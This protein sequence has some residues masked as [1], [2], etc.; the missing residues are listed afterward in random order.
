MSILK[1]R[2]VPTIL[3][4]MLVNNEEFQY[5]N[6]VRFERPD[7]TYTYI[8]DASTDIWWD[9][10]KYLANKLLS[11]GVINESSKASP[12][13]TSVV[14]DGNAI[15][16]VITDIANVIEVTTNTFNIEYSIE[17]NF[18]ELNFRE[19]DKLTII[20]QGNSH[21]AIVIGFP[22][23]NIISVSSSSLYSLSDVV[24]ISLSSEEIV[25]IL[26]D[27]SGPN[28]SSFIN[29]QIDIYRAYFQDGTIIG[30][31]IYMFKGI[32]NGVSFE[33][34]DS[35]IKVTWAITSQWGYFSEVKGRVTSD[36]FH[37]ALDSSGIPQPGSTI[38][39]EYAYDKGFE[40]AETSVNMIAKYVVQTPQVRTKT[41]KFL[42]IVT[43][44]EVETY[45]VPEDR[46]TDLSVNLQAKNI[47]V[48]YGVRTTTGIPVFADTLVGDSSSVY[49]AYVIS[50]GEIGGIY[51]I[52]IENQSL[53][54]TDQADFDARDEA[55]ALA[56]GDTSVSIYCR[57]RADRGDVLTGS[58]A[59]SASLVDNTIVLPD[60]SLVRFSSNYM[61]PIASTPVYSSDSGGLGYDEVLTISSPQEISVLFYTG[62]PDQTVC[63]LLKSLSD[64]QQFKI[65]NSYTT[66]PDDYWGTDHKLLDT[67]YAVAAIKIAEGETTIPDIEYIVRG[68]FI[69]CYNYDYSYE[70]ISGD[71]SK[72]EIGDIVSFSTGTSATIIDKFKFKNI[73]GDN[74]WRFRWDTPPNVLA[75]STFSMTNGSDTWVMGGYLVAPD[76]RV[77]I[78]PAMQLLD[79]MTSTRYGRGIDVNTGIDLVG[80][81]EAARKCDATSDVTIQLSST[82]SIGDTYRYSDP[83][84]GRLIFQGTVSKVKSGNY[85]TFTNVLGKLTNRWNS[86]KS[87]RVGDIL[88]DID[89]TLLYR[90][91][92][93]GTKSAIT[94]N[95]TSITR[96]ELTKVNGT[97]T[98]VYTVESSGNPVRDL[99]DSVIISGYS[100]YDCDSINYWRLCGWDEH[101]Q[102]YVTKYQTNLVIDTSTSI[103]DNIN[104]FLSHFNGILR[105]TEGKYSLDIEGVEPVVE[106]G[107]I[108]NI[109]SDD[110]IGKIQLSDQGTK[111]SFNSLAV[112]FADPAIKFEARNIGFFNSNYLAA[113]GNVPKKG[114]LSVP[115]V[116]NYYNTRLLAEYYLNKSRYGLTINATIRPSGVLFLPGTIIEV[117]YPRYNWDNK[118]FRIISINHQPSTLVDI[119]AE[120]YD[121]SFYLENRISRA[122]GSLSAPITR[123]VSI[124]TPSNLI[125]TSAETYDDLLDGV[126]LNWTNHPRATVGTV[127]TEIYASRSP[128]LYLSI[129]KV[130]EGSILEC[131]ETNHG[132]VVGMPVYP[133]TTY[134]NELFSGGRVYYVK[135]I[136]SNNQFTLTENKQVGDIVPLTTD[137]GVNFR[138]RTGSLLYSVPVPG[139]TYFDNVPATGTQAVEKYYWIRHKVIES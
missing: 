98:S 130:N 23:T 136:I 50:E 2:P 49:V 40:H 85:T 118:P 51:D 78:N 125:V 1:E 79:Y 54:C 14:L 73:D 4:D 41:K 119:V 68:K 70:G 84:T 132:L 56:R 32:I 52:Y 91:N 103:F 42:G 106:S 120:E 104:S 34:A 113:D 71:A 33:D 44:V 89:N 11:L 128:E 80:W 60:S 116:T 75:N 121:E 36:G 45:Y 66:I 83:A 90:V 101:N 19:G 107:D 65:Q 93:D 18:L 6:L 133:E 43:G 53:I 92:T 122:E 57:G 117:T 129:I 46:F 37:R 38:R 3:K 21:D 15:G 131:A 26:L 74:S 99:R 29:R 94:D 28:Y 12:A 126:E 100:L 47:P 108:R 138:V 31:P 102:R 112:A 48:I 62:K 9:G 35:S 17:V 59:T 86:W 76:K 10:N 105:Y 64:Q 95:T 109:T 58:I 25:S 16:S 81:K 22:S 134:N 110:I 97:S 137:S 77:S 39:P 88:Y 72:F 27:K 127:S 111:S 63:P 87:Y 61:P 124:G 24:N 67:A 7:N 69:D 8:T 55:T 96:L 20:A 114:S 135:D 30:S 115:G 139:T 13:T 82:V 5:A 123:I